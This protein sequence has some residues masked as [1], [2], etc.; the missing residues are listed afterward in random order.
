MLVE[1]SEESIIITLK[2]AQVEHKNLQEIRDNIE[3]YVISSVLKNDKLYKEVGDKMP[4]VV[5]KSMHMQVIRQAHERGHFGV[6]KIE[7]IVRKVLWFKGMRPKIEKVVLNCINCILG[8]KYGKQE[9]FLNTI[10]KGENCHLIRITLIVLDR[11]SRVRK[12]IDTSL[13]LLMRLPNLRG[14]MPQSPQILRS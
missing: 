1:E 8:K 12:I 6:N 14:Y 13:W 11:Y 4:V 3:Q 7:A 2:K 5:P 9:S 10:D